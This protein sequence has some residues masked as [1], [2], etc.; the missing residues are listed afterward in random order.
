M[1]HFQKGG[2]LDNCKKGGAQGDRLIRLTQYPPL[3]TTLL[4]N[5]KRPVELV[6]P[7]TSDEAKLCFIFSFIPAQKIVC[8]ETE[9][10][11]QLVPTKHD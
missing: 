11:I 4:G 1:R 2:P 3:V 6:N 10:L 5:L 7:N 9:V 8:L